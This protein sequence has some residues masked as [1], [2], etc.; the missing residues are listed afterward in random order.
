MLLD[1]YLVSVV[2][3]IS[4]SHTSVV[5][6]GIEYSTWVNNDCKRPWLMRVHHLSSLEDAQTHA[7]WDGTI[8]SR[9]KT[10]C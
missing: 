1:D 9:Y 8:L 2:N 3:T 4:S 6:S 5:A 10:P 7:R